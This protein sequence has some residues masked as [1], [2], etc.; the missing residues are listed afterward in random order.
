MYKSERYQVPIWEKSNLSLDEAAAYFN[1]GKDKIRKITDDPYC[2]FVLFVGEK[3]LIKRRLMEQW[4]EG[5]H[6]I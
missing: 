2:E 6:S 3:R 4:L 5:M 1:I